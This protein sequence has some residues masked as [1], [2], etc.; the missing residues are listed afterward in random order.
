MA[1]NF[2]N[3]PSNGDTHTFGGVTYTYNSTRGVWTASSAGSGGGGGGGAS[4]S[5]SDSAPSSPSDGDLWFDTADN[6]LFVYY[7]DTDSSQWIEI[8]SSGGSGSSGGGGSSVTSYANL[9][10]FPTTG[11]TEADMA[12]AEDTNAMYVWD[13]TEWDRFSTG[14]NELPEFTTEPASSYTLAAD[15]TAT[16]VTV[17]AT[18]PEG[19]DITYSHDTSPSNQAQATITNSGGTFTV[20]P[21]TN[22]ANAGNFNLRFKAS[23]GVHVSSK[24]ANF[25]LGF[26]TEWLTKFTDGTN[27]YGGEYIYPY[28]IAKDSADNVYALAGVTGSSYET[29]LLIKVNKHGEH[30]WSKEYA[31]PATASNR[32]LWAGGV[33]VDPNDDNNIYV[34]GTSAGHLDTGTRTAF[35][36]KYNSSGVLQWDKYL[37]HSGS[38]VGTPHATFQSVTV[39]PNGNDI[40]AIGWAY[41]SG[42]TSNNTVNDML[43]TKW[44]SSGVLQWQRSINGALNN[45]ENVGGCTATNTHLYMNGG[46]RETVGSYQMAVLKI[47]NGGLLTWGRY[48]THSSSTAQAYCMGSKSIA[49]DSSENVYMT[50]YSDSQIYTSGSNNAK[51]LFIF[52]LNSSGTLTDQVV[53]RNG[54][55]TDPEYFQG[56]DI[57]LDSSTND[58][59]IGGTTADY[60]SGQGAYHYYSTVLKYSSSLNFVSGLKMG[61][62]LA[63]AYSRAAITKT[64]DRILLVTTLREDGVESTPIVAS[65]NTDMVSN[66]GSSFGPNNDIAIS[67]FTPDN[68]TASTGYSTN[69]WNP[70]LN[71]ITFTTGNHSSSW[72]DNTKTWSGNTTADEI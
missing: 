63:E 16:T 41:N 26:N 33:A 42:G 68:T 44:N 1:T 36:L 27:T 9:A 62:A 18:D 32:D 47:T 48:F 24:I 13:G 69:T 65:L 45:F 25:I 39:S 51:H 56:G 6:S 67:S 72:Q 37:A 29:S 57:A 46:V 20:T 43:I 70:T 15:G 28:S 59:Y 58:L 12:W 2:P 50:G 8:V 30:V 4:V 60:N 55:G 71:T 40:Y 22:A 64:S 17:A 53:S 61:G 54:N 66:F 23:D 10:A 34:T 31:P 7:Q 52:K 11:N 35:I 49:L 14:S 19:F 5:T 38:P 3:S 21:S